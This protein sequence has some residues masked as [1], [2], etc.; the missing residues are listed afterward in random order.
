MILQYV[1]GGTLINMLVGPARMMLAPLLLCPHRD[2]VMCVPDLA[3][4]QTASWLDEFVIGH[5]LCPF[6]KAQ[7]EHTK[8]VVNTACHQDALKLVASELSSLRAI[9]PAE[10]GTTLIVLPALADV[11]ELMDF[12]DHA[13]ALAAADEQD[14]VVQVLAFH[15]VRLMRTPEAARDPWMS[16]SC[17][18]NYSACATSCTRQDA[19]FGDCDND[20]ADLSMQSPLP[21]LHLLRDVDVQ[22]AE[23]RWAQ[24]H[25]PDSPPSI[26]ERN[27]AYLR[28]LGYDKARTLSRAS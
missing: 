1:F 2:L 20:A 11:D 14:G 25:A 15:P 6:A 24:L 23:E 21:M 22:A 26:Q 16:Y 5:N 10:P 4:Q 17:A 18:T 12:R 8:I 13:E 9:A 28:G 27:A 3:L 7:R 19:E